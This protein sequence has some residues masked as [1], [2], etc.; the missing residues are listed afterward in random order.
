MDLPVTTPAVHA[1][2]GGQDRVRS[3]WALARTAIVAPFT[4]RQG[5]ELLFCLAGLPFT[6]INPLVLFVL[7]VDLIWL[8]AD[9]ARGNPSPAEMAVAGA[10]QGLL[11][12]LLVSTPAAR[13]LGALQRTLATRL[14]GVR[15]GV[16][17]PVRRSPGGR[18]WPG[19]APATNQ[20][21]STARTKSASGLTTVNGSPARQNNS[22]RP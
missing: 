2:P 15:V 16:P 8:V 21:R 18:A 14:L 13:R 3:P 1:V 19:P 7:T 9:S 12:V 6:L 5:R 17:P 22:S 4:R 11:L 20:V 10:C